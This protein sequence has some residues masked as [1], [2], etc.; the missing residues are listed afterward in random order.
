MSRKQLVTLPILLIVL[1]SAIGI[2]YAAWF[3]TITIVG[4]AETGELE[5]L[6][7][8]YES[9]PTVAE[10]FIW[11]EYHGTEWHGKPI[12]PGARAEGEWHDK[13]VAQLNSWY[14]GEKS[15]LSRMCLSTT[16]R[17]A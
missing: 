15:T 2:S 17:M 6:F 9:P 4:R 13:D 5:L 12:F 14:E 10:G 7:H 11:T 3:D 8:W 16:N 1:L